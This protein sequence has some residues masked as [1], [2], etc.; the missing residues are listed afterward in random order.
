MLY[1]TTR[2]RWWDLIAKTKLTL[3]IL[4]RY[5]TVVIKDSFGPAKQAR[6]VQAFVHIHTSHGMKNRSVFDIDQV[7]GDRPKRLLSSHPVDQIESSKVHRPGIS[8]QRLFSGEVVIVFE[9]GNGELAEGPIDGRSE[10]EPRVIGFSNGAPAA[11]RPI[12]SN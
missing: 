11:I 4:T 10:T 5:S 6:L 3:R 9:I 8:T 1:V 2:T 7:F 12:N